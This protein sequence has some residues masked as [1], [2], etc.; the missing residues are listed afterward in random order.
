MKPFY[1]LL[2]EDH[3]GVDKFYSG[4]RTA[5]G[6]PLPARSPHDAF[7]FESPLEAAHEMKVINDAGFVAKQ[8]TC[9]KREAAI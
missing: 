4:V 8:I 1:V 2:I 6:D 9:I 7:K 5:K 3:N